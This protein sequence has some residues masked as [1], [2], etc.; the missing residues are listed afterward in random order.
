M[1]YSNLKRFD[2]KGRRLSIFATSKDGNQTLDIYV[3]VCSKKDQFKKEYTRSR[4]NFYFSEGEISFK[5]EFPDDHPQIFNIVVESR[6]GSN[7]STPCKDGSSRV[8]WNPQFFTPICFNFPANSTH[9]RLGLLRSTIALGYFL[10]SD[11]Y[12]IVIPYSCMYMLNKA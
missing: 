4:A 3:Q 1:I 12:R 9:E 7:G 6:L 10:K 11:A 8:K 2:N 5:A